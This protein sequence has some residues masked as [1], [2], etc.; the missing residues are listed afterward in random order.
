MFSYYASGNSGQVLYDM[1]HL[2]SLVMKDNSLEASRNTW[3]MVL[4]ALA[5]KPSPEVLHYWYSKQI[6][7]F[8]PLSEDTA[9]YRR[10]QY[11]NS[12]DYSFD[13][14]WA[15]SCRYL[16]QKRSGYMQ[17]SLNRSL[18][19]APSK[20]LPGVKAPQGKGKG[21]DDKKGK[22]DRSQTLGPK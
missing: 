1:N 21:K 9:H 8:K 16:A 12:T 20:A 11:H 4:S 6:K 14:L 18:N 5:T 3:N 22:K 7:E 17:D 13:L 10:S 2:Q 19:A 15:A